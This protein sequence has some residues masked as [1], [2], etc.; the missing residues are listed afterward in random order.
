MAWLSNG[1]ITGAEVTRL[2]E[3]FVAG[4]RVENVRLVAAAQLLVVVRGWGWGGVRVWRWGQP[5]VAHGLC[6]VPRAVGALHA[7][8]D[9]QVQHDL[10]RELESAMVADE[11]FLAR[12]RAQVLLE[13]ALLGELLVAQVAHEGLL[14]RVDTDVLLE[15]R[16]LPEALSAVVAGVRFFTSVDA[17]VLGGNRHKFMFPVAE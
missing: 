1:L 13:V 7:H 3:Q 16:L 9:V 15:D 6:D 14:S 10:A 12:V 8:A 17:D 2:A 4:G 5:V 11:R